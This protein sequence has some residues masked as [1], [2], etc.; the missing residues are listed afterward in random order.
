MILR[1]YRYVVKTTDGRRI[2]LDAHDSDEAVK[3]SGIPWDEIRKWYPS[4]IGAYPTEEEKEKNKMSEEAKEKLRELKR[5][6][7]EIGTTKRKRGEPPMQTVNKTTGELN[8]EAIKKQLTIAETPPR[9]TSTTAL[10]A[11]RAQNEAPL[12]LEMPAIEA[13]Q[14]KLF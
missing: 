11:K 12:A 6:K 9:Q 14:G 5:L 4:V 7:K 10:R 1:L 3:L 8:A 2:E 13:Q